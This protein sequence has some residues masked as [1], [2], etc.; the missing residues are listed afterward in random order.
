MGNEDQAFAVRTFS[1]R[2]TAFLETQIFFL[3]V[4]EWVVP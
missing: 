2:G 3:P 1:D 4:D